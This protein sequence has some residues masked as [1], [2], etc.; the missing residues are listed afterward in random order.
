MQEE[1]Q[2]QYHW[3]SNS[4]QPSGKTV[5]SSLNNQTSKKRKPKTDTPQVYKGMKNAEEYQQRRKE[6][7]KRKRDI[8][9]REQ[10]TK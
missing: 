3:E 6:L 1:E 8:E 5:C 2:I 7:R 10:L 9:D 4:L